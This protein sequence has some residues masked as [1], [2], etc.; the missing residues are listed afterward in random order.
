MPSDWEALRNAAKEQG[1]RE[2]PIKKGFRL[3]PPDPTKPMVVIHGTPSDRRALANT[4]AQMRRSGLV[5]P[6]PPQ[7]GTK[8]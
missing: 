4:K 1:W 6:W 8:R 5:W 2:E 7:R 3:V